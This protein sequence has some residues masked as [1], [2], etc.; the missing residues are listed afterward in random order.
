MQLSR[1]DVDISVTDDHVIHMTTTMP[2]PYTTV[3]ADLTAFAVRF[4]AVL[5]GRV[6]CGDTRTTERA[7]SRAVTQRME[8]CR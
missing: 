1:L 7:D 6:T 3:A 4:G 2:I 5:N 8:V